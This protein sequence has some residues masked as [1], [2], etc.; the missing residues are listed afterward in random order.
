MLVLALVTERP[1]VLQDMTH[2]SSVPSQLSYAPL[3]PMQQACRAQRCHLLTRPHTSSASMR[4]TRLVHITWTPSRSPLCLLSHT[5]GF[6]K[7]SCMLN[8]HEH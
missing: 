8:F 1:D 6:L 5:C 2:S 3:S 4:I 7:A